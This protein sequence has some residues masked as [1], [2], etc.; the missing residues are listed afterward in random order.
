MDDAASHVIP[1]IMPSREE[2][3][4]K[5]TFRVRLEAICREVVPIALP[6][7]PPFSLQAYGSFA[8][9]F[10]VRGSDL[11]LTVVWDYPPIPGFE[12][13]VASVPRILEA[14]L[15][16]AGLG[17]RVLDRTRVPIIK[18]CEH[19]TPELYHNLVMERQKWDTIAKEE[20][21][22]T[23]RER[24]A[25]QSAAFGTLQH[26]KE[27]SAVE[28]TLQDD[29]R[30]YLNRFMDSAREAMKDTDEDQYFR[31]TDPAPKPWLRE[32]AMGDLDF[33]KTGVGIQCDINFT[34]SL[35]IHNTRLLRCYSLCDVRVRPMVLFVKE[36]ARRRKINSAYSGTLSSYGYVLMVLHY[37]IHVAKPP[38]LP[39]LLHMSGGAVVTEQGYKFSFYD[40]EDAIR[41][42]AAAGNIT[43]NTMPLGVLL[44]NFFHYYGELSAMGAEDRGF[45][46]TRWVL[47]LRSPHGLLWK[48]EKGWT[49]AKNAVMTDKVV[50]QRYLLAIEDPFET[51]H[52]V[53]RTVTHNGIVAIRDEFRRALSIMADLAN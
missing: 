36:W 50:R 39:N 38:V 12:E 11:D 6:E 42:A 28:R 10:A 31:M 43:T 29:L 1:T 17:A 46:W 44:R 14:A 3:M 21:G 27:M 37:L 22:E 20:E 35:A 15:L 45:N 2:L 7:L 8:S 18:V 26:L 30:G 41:R 34:N 48:E 25:P 24:L 4:A 19:P 40:D 47:S 52:N 9:G 53:A 49:A 32:K 51:D 23:L 16:Q 5:D 33:P 13:A